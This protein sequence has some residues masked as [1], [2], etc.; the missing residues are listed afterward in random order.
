VMI[1]SLTEFEDAE[2]LKVKP[3][4][5]SGEYCWTCTSSTIL[6]CIT[7]FHLQHCTYV[8]ADLI[9]YSN[10]KILY[11]EMGEKSVLITSHRYTAEYDQSNTSGKYCVQFISFKNNENGMKVLKWWR[12]ACIEWCF[13]RFE[14]G[15][16][17]DQKYLDDWQTRFEGVH[18]LEHLGG[19]VAPWNV[20][21]YQITKSGNNYSGIEMAT[22]KKFELVFFHF[23]G[24]KFYENNIVSLTGQGYAINK[25]LQEVL[26]K[27]YVNSLEKIRNKINKTDITINANGVSGPSP[28]LPLNLKL[29]IRFYLAGFK[30]SFK[31]F[32][33]TYL[34]HRIA[35]HYFY[36]LQ[37]FKND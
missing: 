35:H 17:G 26:Y 6:Y 21:Q 3:T 28:F 7:N 32:S 22:E 8:D 10:P 29:K 25:N 34:K 33:F 1:I 14:D 36:Y 9:F 11:D 12:N 2:L 20:Q 16:F 24:L 13:N 27:P 31:N 4:R 5:T 23:H 18:E 19:G 15:K 37:D 30:Y